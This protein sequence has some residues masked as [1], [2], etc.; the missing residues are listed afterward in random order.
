[1]EKVSSLLKD[2]QWVKFLKPEMLSL[3]FYILYLTH[4][5]EILWKISFIID[6]F[7]TDREIQRI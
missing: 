6:P 1:M 2:V 4:I 7:S 5:P 3:D